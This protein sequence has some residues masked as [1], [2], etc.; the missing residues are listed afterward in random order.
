MAFEVEYFD[1]SG[2]DATINYGVSLQDG[3]PMD[4]S[5]VAMDII[6]GTSQFLYSNSGDFGVD[7][8]E[9]MWSNGYGLYNRLSA[10]DKIRIIYDATN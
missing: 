3:T 7:G 1:L 10:G 5:N 8:T 9:I 4:S 2:A 6:G